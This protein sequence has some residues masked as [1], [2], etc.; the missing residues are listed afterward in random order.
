M[1]GGSRAALLDVALVVALA[2][3]LFAAGWTVNGW[4]KDLE[5]GRIQAEQQKQ[6]G[7]ALNDALFRLDAAR[8]RGDALE[9]RLAEAEAIRK[10][11]LEIHAREIK[12][13]S[14]GRPCLDAGLV[15]LLNDPAAAGPAADP[16]PAPAGGAV[17][18]DG[19]A[20]SDTDVAL[21]I[22]GAKG[23]YDACRDRLDALIDWHTGKSP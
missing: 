17:A 14:T 2:G 4:R 19:A 7:L 10:T 22:S 12:K 18:E 9:S 15:R 1:I 20:A 13:L 11:A 5:I 6:Q 16:V 8:K 3:L 23:Q 21:W